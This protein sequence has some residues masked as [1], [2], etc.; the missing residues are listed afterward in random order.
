MVKVVE[1]GAGPHGNPVSQRPGKVVAAVVVDG[2]HEAQAE[3]GK[4]ADDVQAVGGARVV[5]AALAEQPL[6]SAERGGGAG[7]AGRPRAL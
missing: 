2:Q 7:G 6:E 5:A 4:D 1:V 3:P